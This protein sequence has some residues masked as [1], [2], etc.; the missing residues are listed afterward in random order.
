MLKTIIMAAGEGT[1]MKSN[2]SKVLH[3]LLNREIIK[4]VVDAS[5]FD[6]SQTIIIG[7][8]NKD[9]LSK[10]F[11]DDIIIEQKIGKDYPYGTG[12]AA[13]L[14]L[15]E[16]SDND[17]VLVLNGDIP[18]ITKSSLEE[19]ISNHI[20][21]DNS[22]SV[23]STKVKNPINY[24]RIIRDDSGDFIGIVEHKDLKLNQDIINEINTGIY[25]F[26]G[27][28]LKLALSKLDTNNEQSELYLTDCI[29][30]LYNDGKKVMAFTASDPDEFYGINNKKELAEAKKILQKRVNENHMLNGVVIEDPE[31]AIIDPEVII[32]KD[33]IVS[34]PVKIL[35]KSEIGE[36]CTIEGS[37]R[38]EDSILK[39]NIKIDNS[40]IEKSFLDE[41]T[42]VGP[43][44]HLRPNAKL[45]K[46]VHIGNFVEVK[47]STLGDGTKAGHLAYIGDSDLGSKINIGC[48]VIFVN[49]DGKF[50]HRSVVKDN[51]F[52][53]SNS[54][55]VAPVIIEEEAYIAAGSTI[56]SDVEAGHLSI[57]RA[58]QKNVAGYAEKKRKRD[59]E[60]EKEQK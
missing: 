1:R 39:D 60:K 45:G 21:N 9:D 41:G 36:N 19:F 42:D 12:Y 31:M 13:S 51:A 37:S 54:N 38:I 58:E 50:K 49:Y 15:N 29:E 28:D 16:I 24:G 23:L 17:Q 32:G 40:V 27:S 25:I 35:G 8:K 6:E 26:K 33:T 10:I 3:K 56:T 11:P 2:K 47:N 18:L 48:G 22:A 4:Y 5:R 53:G 55:I 34:G 44:S 20:E 14:A 7:G 46:N 52:I 43:Y 30:I 59:L 57:E